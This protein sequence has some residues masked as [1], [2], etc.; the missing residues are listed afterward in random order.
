MPDLKRLGANIRYLREAYGETQE[1]LGFALGNLGKDGDYLGKTT[2]SNYEKG[3]REPDEKI[4]AAIARHF[5]VSVE[6]LVDNDI[7]EILDFEKITFDNTTFYRRIDEILPIITSD[8]AMANKDFNKAYNAHI[9]IYN[10]LKS[11]T[12]KSFDMLETCFN[13]Y[14]E[15]EGKKESLVESAC[16]FLSLY[17]LLLLMFKDI[18]SIIAEPPACLLQIAKHDKNVKAII[19]NVDPSFEQ[20]SK[21]ILEL[22]AGEDFQEKINEY[23]Y[24]LK[25]SPQW[26]DLA[27]YYLALQYVLNL[28]QNSSTPEFNRKVG[29]EMLNNLVSVKNYYA[30]RYILF[31]YE[32]YG[33]ISPQSVDDK[34]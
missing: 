19:D 2:I 30:K 1:Q 29:A 14:L 24:I 23:K 16:N 15:A 18:P 17:Y 21:I 10:G 25:K 32:A 34:S 26:G 4:L 33:L 28:V 6:D 27:D 7:K 22:F 13:G 9:K 3:I 31:Y 20:D 12:L 5:M 11:M 8:V